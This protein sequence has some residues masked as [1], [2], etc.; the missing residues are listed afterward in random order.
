MNETEA[1][2]LAERAF[3]GTDDLVGIPTIN[4]SAEVAAGVPAED[5]VTAWLHDTVEDTDLAFDD[6]RELGV[7]EV[8]LRAL[9]LLTRDPADGRTYRQYIQAIA[10]AD[11]PEGTRGR[12]V[13]RQDLRVNIGRKRP[14]HM[15]GMVSSRYLPALAVI[16]QAMVRRG[17]LDQADVWSQ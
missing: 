5:R 1:R 12:R 7:D 13:K 15:T 16:E 8:D 11:G 6:L 2:A 3:A 14:E 17:E 9:A 10:D 4:H